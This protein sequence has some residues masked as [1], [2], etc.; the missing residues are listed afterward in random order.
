VTRHRKEVRA[1]VDRFLQQLGEPCCS[2]QAIRGSAESVL[3]RIQDPS[4]IYRLPLARTPQARSQNKMWWL[5]PAPVA[6]LGAIVL[7]FVV[8][9]MRQEVPVRVAHVA[10]GAL[11]SM[12]PDT[13]RDFSA[14]DTILTGESVITDLGASII[15]DEGSRV[16]LKAGA[17]LRVEKQTRGLSIHLA[18][19]HIIV[20]ASKQHNRHL[21][22]QTQDC[23]V[24]VAGTVFAV[25]AE[26][27]GS[28]VSV[29][30]GEV[31]VTQGATLKILQRGQQISTSPNLE[32]VRLEQEIEWSQE[33]PY[34]VTLLTTTKQVRSTPPVSGSIQGT[35]L[36]ALTG[37]P[38]AHATVRMERPGDSESFVPSVTTE[39]DGLFVFANVPTGQ[40]YFVSAEKDGYFRQARDGAAAS[41]MRLTL[42]SNEQL[43]NVE[44]RL[45]Q[46]GAVTGTIL[47]PKGDGVTGALVFPYRQT[48]DDQGNHVFQLASLASITA[49][50][51]L[52]RSQVLGTFEPVGD[53]PARIVPGRTNS[54]GEFRIF[55]LEPGNFVFHVVP[56]TRFA[57]F[58][59]PNAQTASDARIVE[60]AGNRETALGALS[61][62]ANTSAV[63]RARLVNRTGVDAPALLQVRRPGTDRAI[64]M[65]R[66]AT[67]RLTEIGRLTAGTYLVDAIVASRVEPLFIAA[68]EAT[69]E[70][71]DRDAEVDVVVDRGPS[72][73][74]TVMV[75]SVSKTLRPVAG[76]EMRFQSS[77]ISDL[78]FIFKSGSDGRFSVASL[79][80]GAFRLQSFSGIPEG[81]CL[82]DLQEGDRNVFRDGIEIRPDDASISV[83]LRDSNAAL[84]GKVTDDE[85]NKVIGA[86]VALVPSDQSPYSIG[87]TDQ[88]GEFELRCLKP[89]DFQVYAWRRVEGS[90][91]RN[92][93]FMRHY[94]SKGA[95]V[96]IDNGK[97]TTVNL[98]IQPEER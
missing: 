28:R 47:D 36:N 87:T 1:A 73:S 66:A 34:L 71:R 55:N 30:E 81:L 77:H 78:K 18:H 69:V 13:S 40:S 98:T 46:A 70:I 17:R 94:E 12:N 93:E 20:T 23:L 79:P 57:P 42:A 5:I 48:F 91:F 27:T 83:T 24:S 14:G 61:M 64:L 92:S 56:P 25:N 96:R 54:R 10:Y 37:E 6:L 76:V 82:S 53:D 62:T 65:T 26:D 7:W 85:R 11:H 22:V 15:F 35:V 2:S 84:R 29:L 75:E 86:T 16:E 90:A 88:N 8:S 41:S 38:V 68:G 45:S 39:N 33:K 67:G 51:T 50:L 3:S 72:L 43:K 60:V 4:N 21:H 32:P 58:Y 63:L 52:L 19:G 9:P 59:Y 97:T 89:G 31:H 80:S 44:L 74:G 95:T 49:P